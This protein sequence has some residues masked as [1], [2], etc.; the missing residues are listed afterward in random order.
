MTVFTMF[1]MRETYGVAILEKK[2]RRLR[3]ET[4]NKKLRS[5]F[6]SRLSP[7]DHFLRAIVRPTKMLLFS[8][9]CSLLSLYMAYVYGILYLIFTTIT[10]L[11]VNEYG[12]SQGSAGLAFL[13]IGIGMLLGLVVF[14]ATSDRV[15]ATLAAKRGGER[16]PEYRF[17][18]LFVGASLIPVGLFLYGWSAE[19]RLHYVIPIVGTGFV[20]AG[21]LATFMAIGTYLVE[22][23]T[24][25]SIL[26]HRL[27][28]RIRAL[29]YP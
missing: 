22:V 27:C 8:P 2:A 25:C 20:G 9:I 7:R 13:G 19:Y 24:A 17:P 15:V 21:L 18:G 26:M 12:F 1:V 6:D 4:G 16:K 5:K 14:G 29:T 11:F 3:E 23:S 10:A 28:D